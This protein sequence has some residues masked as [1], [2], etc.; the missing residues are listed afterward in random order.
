MG[1]GV[2]YHERYN[3]C[4]EGVRGRVRRGCEGLGLSTLFFFITYLFLLVEILMLFCVLYSIP[5]CF[6]IDP[7][8]QIPST[9]AR[10]ARLHS[11]DSDA[12]A[13][14]HACPLHRGSDT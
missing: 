14:D 9:R 4:L 12:D 8:L 6:R 7:R 11:N 3:I 1:V 10:T 2:R 13:L 5:P